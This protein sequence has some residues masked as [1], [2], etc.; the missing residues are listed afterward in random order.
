MDCDSIAQT[1]KRAFCMKMKPAQPADAAMIATLWHEG[2]HQAHAAIV[3][4]ALT[5]LRTP[6][7]FATRTKAHLDQTHV[8]WIDG[9]TAGF[10]MLDRDEVYQFYVSTAFQRAGTATQMMH[11][12]ET[13]LGDG[14]KW[15]ACSVGND[16]AARFYEKTG[17]VRAGVIPYEVE[18][19][20]GP[21][22]VKVWRYEKNVV[23]A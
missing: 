11:E 12:A 16:R 5:A 23:L 22:V 13:A 14:P 15:L 17:W 19:A 7:E 6:E 21:L 18:T 20:E 8:A 3:P 2:W 9:Q 10:F 1:D 4:A